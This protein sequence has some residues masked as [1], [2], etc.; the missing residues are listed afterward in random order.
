MSNFIY[1]KNYIFE[2]KNLTWQNAIKKF[3]FQFFIFRDFC[4]LI[5][6]SLHFKWLPIFV[7]DFQN[8]LIFVVAL[9]HIKFI[10]PLEFRKKNKIAIFAAIIYDRLLPHNKNPVKMW[11]MYVT[12]FYLWIEKVDIKRGRKFSRRRGH[13]RGHSLNSIRLWM[14]CYQFAL[15]HW[16]FKIALK[17]LVFFQQTGLNDWSNI[18]THRNIFLQHLSAN[19]PI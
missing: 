8:K 18:Y 1:N 12:V 16:S 19:E 7:F 11:N 6:A 2:F 10:F 4:I 13:G 9:A 3:F 15:S 17:A 5:F 14:F